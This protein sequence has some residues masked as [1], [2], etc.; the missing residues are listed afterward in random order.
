MFKYI[1]WSKISDDASASVSYGNKALC[2]NCVKTNCLYVCICI[3]SHPLYLHLIL[4]RFF[5]LAVS[6]ERW[7]TTKVLLKLEVLHFTASVLNLQSQKCLV[8]FKSKHLFFHSGAVN[9]AN[10][11]SIWRSAHQW[12]RHTFSGMC[13]RSCFC[14][15][16]E[17]IFVIVNYGWIT[18]G[19]HILAT[20]D[21]TFHISYYM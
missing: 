21:L 3:L 13:T 8:K 1:R 12:N 14:A 9:E 15:L 4:K 2:F 10:T 19:P 11:I 17:S 7:G 6:S 5:S 16:L 18:L 20:P